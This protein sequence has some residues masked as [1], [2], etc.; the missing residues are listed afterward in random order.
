MISNKEIAV[1]AVKA[2]NI[3]RR[4]RNTSPK[5]S[6]TM[7]GDCS[8]MVYDFNSLF[9]VYRQIALWECKN[10]LLRDFFLLLRSAS[11][12]LSSSSLCKR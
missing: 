4:K 12:L 9:D 3:R 2:K 11:S 7:A 1:S 5:K 6:Y 10:Y 8:T